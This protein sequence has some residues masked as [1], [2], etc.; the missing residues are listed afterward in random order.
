MRPFH[1]TARG[2]SR[3]VAVPV[4]VA[5]VAAGEPMA[6]CSLGGVSRGPTLNEGEM[7][8]VIL[9]PWENPRKKVVEWDLIEDLASSHLL[10]SY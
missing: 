4:A 9:K 8:M 10:H 6:W 5:T 3:A 7:K 2:H 1:K